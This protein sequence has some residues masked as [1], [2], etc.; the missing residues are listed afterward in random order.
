MRPAWPSAPT[1][2]KPVTPPTAP[3]RST[4]ALPETSTADRRNHALN[5]R[6]TRC[7]GEEAARSSGRDQRSL[8]LE[9]LIRALRRDFELAC[10]RAFHHRYAPRLANDD[11]G[12]RVTGVIG[13][14]GDRHQVRP[15]VGGHDDCESVISGLLVDR[16][17]LN[18]TDG[19]GCDR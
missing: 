13:P 12:D 9:G 3:P 5:T 2:P 15:V 11:D 14:C 7:A 1:R 16:R 8:E 6:G 18:I 10:E 4:P 17:P 19:C